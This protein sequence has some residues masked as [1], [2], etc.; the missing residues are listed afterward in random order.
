MNHP[1]D[2][3]FRK[4]MDDHWQREAAQNERRGLK[5]LAT[6]A[7]TFATDLETWIKDYLT[8]PL[9]L[10]QGAK[11]SGFTKDHLFR[12][13]HDGKLK[14][15]GEPRSPRVRRED[16]PRKPGYRPLPDPDPIG[17]AIRERS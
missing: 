4:K 1:L 8:E 3:F 14:N 11:E 15:Y 7:R 6:F 2:D 5:E 9:D 16:L 17:E 13:I 10:D 12:L